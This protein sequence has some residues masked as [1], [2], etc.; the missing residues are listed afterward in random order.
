[1]LMTIR[2]VIDY[3]ND[4][5]QRRNPNMNDVMRAG[6]EGE[7]EELFNHA[8][9]QSR[10]LQEDDSETLVIC[11]EPY[12]R[13]LSHDEAEELVDKLRGLESRLCAHYGK[14]YLEIENYL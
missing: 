1:M 5:G 14:V 9:L 11:C 12:D 2:E 7:A 13:D 10:S 3:Q 4:K 6:I 8:W